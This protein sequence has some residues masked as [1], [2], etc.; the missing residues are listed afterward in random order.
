MLQ[1]VAEHFELAIQGYSKLFGPEHP[2]TVYASARFERCEGLR[3]KHRTGDV[4]GNF[5]DVE[6]GSDGGGEK[7][8]DGN[9]MRQ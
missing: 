5:D 7:D 9:L 2:K 8:G 4:D 1:E 6:S 3:L